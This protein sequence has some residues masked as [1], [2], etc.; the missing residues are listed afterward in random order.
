M[1]VAGRTKGGNEDLLLSRVRG[2]QLLWGGTAGALNWNGAGLQ[3]RT[4]E[5]CG[6]ILQAG[7]L[8]NLMRQRDGHLQSILQ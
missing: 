3:F 4:A 5:A 6:L 1:G 8:T 7:P 2:G